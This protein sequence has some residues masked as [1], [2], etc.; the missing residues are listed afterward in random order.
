M[1]TLR[2]Y[3]DNT[4][5]LKN[6]HIFFRGVRGF[7]RKL[8]FNKNSL[9]T[10][11]IFPTL[12]C[13]LNCNMC[14]M[15]KYKHSKRQ[16]LVLDDYSRLAR[17]GAALGAISVN[18]LGGEPFLF[19]DLDEIIRIF[20]QE[21]YLTYIVSNSLLVTRERLSLL[22]KAGLDAICFSLDSLNEWDNDQVRGNKGHQQSVFKAAKMVQELG[23]TVSFAPVFFHNK[24]NMGLEVIKYCQDQGISANATQVAAVGAWED[25]ELL[26]KEEHEQIRRML[27]KYSRFTLDWVLTYS[28]KYC[29]PAG[30]EKIAITPF[31]DVVGCSINP[32]AFGNIQNEP[33]EKV[34]R[35][36]GCF[37]QYK[38]DSPVC[39]SSEDFEFIDKYLKPFRDCNEYPIDYKSHPMIN[40]DSEKELFD[41]NITL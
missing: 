8:I 29:C 33:L 17:E 7:I 39:L 14:S 35:R 31:G 40:K 11:E 15:E 25:G 12:D 26:T 27:K 9:K 16:K 41:K 20:K 38:K 32:L 1:R 22:K 3:T 30:K 18:I 34:W 13:N 19:K 28:L 37:S 23:I 21:H 4:W 6:P 10:I 24:I 5:V 36:M 2:A